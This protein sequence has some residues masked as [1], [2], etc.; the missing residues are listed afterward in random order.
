[1][2][3]PLA[4]A[5]IKEKRRRPNHVT[6][7]APF[8]LLLS[9]ALSALSLFLCHNYIL[10]RDVSWTCTHQVGS[11][12][13]FLPFSTPPMSISNMRRASIDGISPLPDL[14]FYFPF[15]TTQS[16]SI[17]SDPAIPMF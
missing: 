8:E 7:T 11:P 12:P 9:V 13:K 5:R 16:R 10:C 3:Q 2:P 6:W 15:G 1:L 17:S 14:F 4:G